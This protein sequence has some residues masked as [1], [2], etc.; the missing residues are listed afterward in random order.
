MANN[1]VKIIIET[2]YKGQG[3]KQAK[4]DLEEL[5]SGITAKGIGSLS[6]GLGTLAA[7]FG[8][9]GAAAVA[10]GAAIKQAIDLGA[11]GAQLSRVE[12]SFY[13]LATAAGAS[14]DEIFQSLD[15]AARG[16]ISNS[17]LILSANRAMML[18]LGA[19]AEQLGNLLEI[20]AFRGKALGVSTQQAF[21]DIV[22][23]IGRNSPMI[24]D[25]LGII[26]KGWNEEANAAGVAYDAHF[27]LNKVL[28]DGNQQMA[29]QGGY[30]EDTAASYERL[31]AGLKNAGDE[32]KKNLG[33]AL[34]PLVDGWNRSIDA[35]ERANRLIEQGVAPQIAMSMALRDTNAGLEDTAD[36][37]DEAAEAAASYDRA[38]APLPST[39][40]ALTDSVTDNTEALKAQSQAYAG[41]LS[42]ATAINRDSEKFAEDELSRTAQLEEIAAKK[43]QLQ[44]EMNQVQAEGNLSMARRNEFMLKQIELDKQAEQ[45]KRDGI[46]AEEDLKD[47]ANKR[48][49]DQVQAQVAAEGITSEEYRRLQDLQVQLG[50][51]TRADADRAIQERQTADEFASAIS[52][53]IGEVQTL[54]D[55]L[56]GIPQNSPYR[57]QIIIDTIGSVPTF[58]NGIGISQGGLSNMPGFASGGSFTVPGTGNTDQP[59]LVGLTPG[60]QVT[61][62]PQGQA[63]E[64]TVNISVGNIR[65]LQ[66][67][68]YLAQE[69]ARRLA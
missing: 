4:K 50:L 26:T 53:Q 34:L 65:S 7:T 15:R 28:E 47:A 58:T 20:A 56:F 24:L 37:T 10:A 64:A 23:G 21:N 68:D 60:E 42:A 59:Y 66:D 52:T 16:T 17:D 12:D 3:T 48:I 29:A 31:S 39:V 11:E 32:A 51:V 6:S 55:E 57:A 9:V 40:S 38:L 1:T 13:S 27:L 61:V 63:R 33:E 45:I 49:F 8:T 5:N 69:V 44:L 35:Q 14:G 36:A 43:V 67:M 25:N 46:K 30:V 22:T 41:L 2:L 19:D 54:A 18:G 62:T